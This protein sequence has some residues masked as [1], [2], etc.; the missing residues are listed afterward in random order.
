[1]RPLSLRID[2]NHFFYYYYH[3]FCYFLTDGIPTTVLTTRC[4]AFAAF[5]YDINL[6]YEPFDIFSVFTVVFIGA[7]FPFRWPFAG[8]LFFLFFFFLPSFFFGSSR[9][10]LTLLASTMADR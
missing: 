1:M 9:F 4:V 7:A 10:H 3:I 5:F 2:G 6:F 8:R